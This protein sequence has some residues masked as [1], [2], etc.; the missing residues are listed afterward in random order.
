MVF[1][2]AVYMPLW[3]YINGQFSVSRAGGDTMM[4]MLVDGVANT[5]LVIP[6]IF[7]MAKCTSIGPVGMY[8]II[9]AVEIPKIAVAHFW[10]K[11]EHWLVNLAEKKI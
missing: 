5:G 11:K 8:A 9:K 4:G 1:V 3:V 6:G 10:L 2:M 7:I